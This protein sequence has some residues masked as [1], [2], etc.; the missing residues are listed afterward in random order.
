MSAAMTKA[1]I[2]ASC[3]SYATSRYLKAESILYQ[4]ACDQITTKTAKALCLSIGYDIDFRQKDFGYIEALDI[5]QGKY[6]EF[7]EIHF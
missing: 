1:A 4:W 6:G 3:H 2:Y 5:N 7:V